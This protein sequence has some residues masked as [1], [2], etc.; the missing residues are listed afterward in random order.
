[1]R[2]KV[3]PG[4]RL[5]SAL[6]LVAC[7]GPWAQPTHVT[8]AAMPGSMISGQADVVEATKC[9]P[10]CEPRGGS[11]IIVIVDRPI[12]RAVYEAALAGG[13]CETPVNQRPITRFIGTNGGRAH[14]EVPVLQLTSG[15]YVIILRQ[16]GE[17]KK[18]GSCGTIKR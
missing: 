7:A 5:A 18:P 10:R 3:A 17:S 9:A 1:M 4:G 12:A 8:L 11:D 2:K 14:V 15:S 16:M 6:C 13:S